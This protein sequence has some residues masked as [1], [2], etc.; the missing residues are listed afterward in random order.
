LN[1]SI[2][3]FVLIENLID[4]LIFFIQFNRKSLFS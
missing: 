1:L 4:L 2:N 3:W